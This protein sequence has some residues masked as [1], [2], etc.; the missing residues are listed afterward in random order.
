MY[1]ENNFWLLIEKNGVCVHVCKNAPI[2]F[3]LGTWCKMMRDHVVH[4][5]PD[6]MNFTVKYFYYL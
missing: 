4:R 3:L 1:L 2:Y 5:L 6:S